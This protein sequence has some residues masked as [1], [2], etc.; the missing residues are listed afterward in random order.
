MKCVSVHVTR[1]W[2]RCK[3]CSGGPAVLG[4]LVKE[5]FKK[6]YPIWYR[7]QRQEK[8]FPITPA[9]VITPPL[10]KHQG[11]WW[12]HKAHMLLSGLPCGLVD[13]H[14]VLK[15]EAK[16]CWCRKQTRSILGHCVC[17]SFVL[18]SHWPVLPSSHVE[19]A[20]SSACR[21]QTEVVCIRVL[22]ML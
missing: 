14:M 15:P 18:L 3:C 5:H 11:G 9:S 12:C 2:S 16:L 8:V 19:V 10:W 22:H 20:L 17:V 6:N 21:P 1:A 13:Q 7:K 4:A